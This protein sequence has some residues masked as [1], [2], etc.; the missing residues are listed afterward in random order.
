[1]LVHELVHAYDQCRAHVRWADCRHHACSEVRASN[2]SGECDVS[3]EI[4]RG[5]FG[6]QSQQQACV[7][8]RA[9]LSVGF[10][11]HCAGIAKAA[12]DHIFEG[13]YHDT[14]PFDEQP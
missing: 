14:A 4:A 11:E 12:V 7:R 5:N 9:L 1:M 13:C 3:N 8:R 2:L 10:N 6:V